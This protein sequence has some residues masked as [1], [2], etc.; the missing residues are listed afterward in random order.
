M[1]WVFFCC[2]K[3][4]LWRMHNA[5]G[6]ALAS[7]MRRLQ[8][9]PWIAFQNKKI[10]VRN[11]QQT[12]NLVNDLSAW[13]QQNATPMGSRAV[14]SEAIR[15]HLLSQHQQLEL[16]SVF[17]EVGIASHRSNEGDSNGWHCKVTTT[18]VLAVDCCFFSLRISSWPW[19]AFWNV[20]QLFWLFTSWFSAFW[21]WDT[22]DFTLT[23]ILGSSALIH[24]FSPFAHA[25]EC[26]S[27]FSTFFCIHNQPT[28]LPVL[29]T[30]SFQSVTRATN[31]DIHML[32]TQANA[33]M[34]ICNQS[35]VLVRAPPSVPTFGGNT[36]QEGHIL[37]WWS[38]Q[39]VNS[40]DNREATSL[41]DQHRHEH[42]QEWMEQTFWA[43]RWDLT[44]RVSLSCDCD[45]G[46]ESLEFAHACCV[47]TLQEKFC[48][49]LAFASRVS[50]FIE[51][52]HQQNT[53]N[54]GEY[55]T[56]ASLSSHK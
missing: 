54:G 5:V 25:W 4:V 33:W 3:N 16:S 1:I 40:K 28:E 21:P 2:A 48:L 19:I 36:Q 6:P 32:V 38:L 11:K 52:W 8:M 24:S 44:S 31:C 30:G 43:Q 55:H 51:R 56:I 53:V 27:G 29:D 20:H 49:R 10:N 41:L 46:R 45:L 22:F 50:S 47:A 12:H 17:Q 15:I 35:V 13:T 14:M 9:L 37:T 26:C 42:L 7:Q 39:R 23:S 34:Q 18:A